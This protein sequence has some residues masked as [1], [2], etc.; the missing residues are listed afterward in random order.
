MLCCAVLRVP[1]PCLQV[2]VSQPPLLAGSSSSSSTQQVL[3][4]VGCFTFKAGTVLAAVTKAE[5]VGG[6]GRLAA[7]LSGFW[8]LPVG[9]RLVAVGF[10]PPLAVGFWLYSLGFGMERAY[11]PAVHWRAL[12]VCVCVLTD[13]VVCCMCM[14][15]C[16]GG[17]AAW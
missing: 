9:F 6:T 14:C 16:A 2:T 3:A 8:P 1:P 15:V 17:S 7:G 10:W 11:I 12:Y 13:R 5:Q 4:L